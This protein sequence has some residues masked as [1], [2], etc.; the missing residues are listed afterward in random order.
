[1]LRSS[2]AM[3]FVAFFRSFGAFV[4]FIALSLEAQGESLKDALASAYA[5]NPQIAAALL[6]VK[7]SAEDIALRKAG[8][9][10]SINASADISTSWV[11]RGGS[12]TTPSSGSIGLSYRQML[13]DN[14]KTDA[15]IEQA[16]AYSEVASQGLRDAIQNLLL[17]AASSYID[18]VRETNLVQLRAENVAFYQAQLRSSQ[19]RLNIGTGTR[20]EISQ[21]KARLAQAIASYKSAINNLRAAQ[22]SYQR[23]I[24]HKPQSLSLNYN[25]DGL[26]PRSLDE[27]QDYADKLHPAIL[28]AKAQLLA[29]QSASDAAKRAFGPT[30]TLIGNIGSSTDFVSG[31]TTPS[32]RVTLSLNIPIY[33]GGAMSASVRKANFNQIKSEIDVLSARDQVRAAVVS[34]WSNMQNSLAQIEAAKSAVYSSKQVLQGIIEER[35][36]GQRTTLDVLNARA[37]L[38]TVQES[39]IIAQSNRFVAAFSLIAATG[40]LSASDL[41]LPVQIQTNIGINNIEDIW[42]DLR[43]LNE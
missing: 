10:P 17:S 20:T 19:D 29:S 34:S 22:A 30:L 14:L 9:L 40:R 27:A 18:V 33:Q 25:F 28:S 41:G 38:T 21:A 11:I 35:N 42:L 13:F 36:V 6:S 37:D 39:E 5:N 1:M 32:A 31:T 4:F 15:E 26:I 7:A 2:I 3:R 23:W 12:V 8:K 43:S 24:G 16:R